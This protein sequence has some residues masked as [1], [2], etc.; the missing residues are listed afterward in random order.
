[1]TKGLQEETEATQAHQVQLITLTIYFKQV[2]QGHIRVN[3]LLRQVRR[4][5]PRR[6]VHLLF[7]FASVL[8][9]NIYKL[10]SPSSCR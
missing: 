4:T 9:A 5:V 1:M 8:S 3:A 10:I 7:L 2:G 6:S